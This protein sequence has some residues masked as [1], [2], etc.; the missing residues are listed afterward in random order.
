[1]QT[2]IFA[3]HNQN[4]FD[5][6]KE[7]IKKIPE[8]EN[9][10]VIS[11]TEAGITEEIV[12]DGDTY[13]ENALI[14]ARFVCQETGLP[15]LADDSGTE[16][17]ALYGAP[18]IYSARFMEDKSYKEKCLAILDMMKNKDDRTAFFSCAL[19]FIDKNRN[20][21]KQFLAKTE[22]EIVNTYN[23]YEYGFGYD[24]IFYSYEAKAIFASIP[25]DE[26]FK[27]SHRG[28]ANRLLVE[29]LKEYYI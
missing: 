12:E 13:E 5:E 9:W 16:I 15:A 22:G 27:Y 3:T 6:M 14:K 4:K 18:G 20:I 29:Y 24:P 2:I 19:T 28:K 7:I 25:T 1:M 17:D 10:N 21:Q 11:M 23:E 8:M 26:K